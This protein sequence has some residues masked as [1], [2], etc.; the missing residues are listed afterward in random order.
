MIHPV[1]LRGAWL[2]VLPL[3]LTAC[4]ILLWTTSMHKVDS[5]IAVMLLKLKLTR[6]WVRTTGV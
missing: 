3:V 4:G 5:S 2:V 1:N 6:E